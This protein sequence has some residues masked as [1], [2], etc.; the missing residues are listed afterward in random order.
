V[1]PLAK[2]SLP[3][4][5]RAYYQM[6]DEAVNAWRVKAGPVHDCD[7]RQRDQEGTIGFLNTQQVA[8]PQGQHA[9]QRC[10]VNGAAG[11]LEKRGDQFVCIPDGRDVAASNIGPASAPVG[12]EWAQ[13]GECDLGNGEIGRLVKQ[14]DRLVCK[15]CEIDM[16][17]AQAKRDAAYWQSVR[18][19]ES[20]WRHYR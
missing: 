9:G 10:T 16:D 15:P 8:W 11:H 2:D 18:D 5:D 19:A 14:G 3:A 6:C 12:G 4:N 7:C 1:N 13:G 20:E 17:S